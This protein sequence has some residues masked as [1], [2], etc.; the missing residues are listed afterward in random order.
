MMVHPISAERAH[1]LDSCTLCLLLQLLY[2]VIA[3]WKQLLMVYKWMGATVP[4]ILLCVKIGKWLNEAH[5]LPFA[6]YD[7]KQWEG[8]SSENSLFGQMIYWIQVIML[9]FR[10]RECSHTHM[11]FL[12]VEHACWC[13][14][15]SYMKSLFCKQ[16]LEVS[17][18]GFSTSQCC[19]QRHSQGNP[20]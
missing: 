11:H 7:L 1:I 13:G 6:D 4:I 16:Y 18:N 14:L 8:F 17:I 12:R 19:D 5:R 20:L 2:S 15:H 9:T 3:T 10:K